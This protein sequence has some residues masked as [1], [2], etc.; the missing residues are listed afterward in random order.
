[1]PDALSTYLMH[2][3]VGAYVAALVSTWATQDWRARA[4]C[5]GMNTSEFFAPTNGSMRLIREVCS[6]CPVRVDCLRYAM[7]ERTIGIY[8]G[9]TFRQRERLRVRREAQAEADVVVYV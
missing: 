4:R 5:R 6:G 8:G 1:M 2:G 9:T 7:R 3:T